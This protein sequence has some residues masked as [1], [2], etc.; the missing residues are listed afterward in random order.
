MSES[1]HNQVWCKDKMHCKPILPYS[2]MQCSN[3]PHLAS[4]SLV[5]S[6]ACFLRCRANL[7]PLLME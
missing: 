3:V 2:A 1:R 4:I 5:S 7:A 6:V